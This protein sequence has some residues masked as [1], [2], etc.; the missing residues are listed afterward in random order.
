M[1]M[2]AFITFTGADDKTP[3]D[4]LAAFAARHPRT[5]FGILF[6][7]SRAGLSRYPSREWVGLLPNNLMLAAH[8]CG[9]WAN[10]LAVDGW[11]PDVEAQLSGFGR[12]Q[13]NIAKP[14]SDLG[15]LI[16]FGA[17]HSVEII[18]Q[19]RDPEIFPTEDR[20][21]W[22]FDASGGRGVMPQS[23][24]THPGN[25]LVGYAGGL[26]PATVHEALDA[27]QTASPF[28]ID[29][30]SKVRDQDDLFDLDLCSAVVAHSGL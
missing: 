11:Q 25:R 20:V 3:P 4:D 16:Q 23:W 17:R 6:S 12:V 5:E 30:E 21:S 26:G 7:R 8:V 15:P 2:P 22:L 13:I 14:P 18:L 19:C 29:M 28:W 27:I 9:R 24:P 10:E 1:P